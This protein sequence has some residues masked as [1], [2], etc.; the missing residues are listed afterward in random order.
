MK[1]GVDHLKFVTSNIEVKTFGNDMTILH[2]NDFKMEILMNKLNKFENFMT[3]NY[4]TVNEFTDITKITNSDLSK[5]L[6]DVR[7]NN[8]I[9]IIII[10]L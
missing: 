10:K 7:I 9:F 2:T 4:I 1:I 8:N 6:L 5:S 3:K